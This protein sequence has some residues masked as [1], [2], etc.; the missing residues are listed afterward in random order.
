MPDTHLEWGRPGLAKCG[1][2]SVMT[3]RDTGR[4][5]C[6]RCAPRDVLV[7]GLADRYRLEASEG[8]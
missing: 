4:V 1:K 3:S 5:D 6:P 2:V 8:D 7:R